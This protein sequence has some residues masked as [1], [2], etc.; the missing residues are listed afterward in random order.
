MKKNKI[1]PQIVIAAIIEK[2][3]HFLIAKR[4]VGKMHVGKWEFPGGT[5][6]EGENHKQC[7]KRELQ[8][9]FSITVEVDDLVCTSDHR[10]TPDWTIKLLAYRTRVVSGN[11][12]LNDHE[13]I[14]WVKPKELAYY[15]FPEADRPL[16]EKLMRESVN[17]DAPDSHTAGRA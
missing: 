5:L 9:E 8:E 17:P 13:E 1:N 15:D 4:K 11:F 2:N 7:L 16:V 14:R 6:E 10:Y 3:G 12:H